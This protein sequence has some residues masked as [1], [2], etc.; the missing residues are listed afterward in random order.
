[1][2]K[3]YLSIIIPCLNEE[4]FLPKLLDDLNK[5]SP[6]NFEVIIIDGNSEDKT[7]QVA[8]KFKAKYPLHVFSTKTRNVS[9]QRNLG[10]EK[11]HGEVL[12]FFDADTRIPKQYLY[13][14][15]HAFQKK[16][17]HFLTTYIKVTSTKP[18]EKLFAVLSNSIFE[19][20]KVFQ[21]PF[22]YGAMQAVK[23]GAFFDIGG[24]DIKTKFSED[25]Q[26]FLKLNEYKYKYLLLKKPCYD[27][28]LRRLEKEGIVKQLTDY[29]QINLNILFK[30]YHVPLK[31]AYK[32]GG[33]TYSQQIENTRYHDIFQP[34]FSNI[35]QKVKKSNKNFQTKIDKIFSSKI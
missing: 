10:A 16:H 19:I 35:S 23:R 1:M 6:I 2:V 4:H 14:I 21:T 29:I 28:S 34:I 5:Q 20:G 27:Y 25:T 17:P 24:Y 9:Y 31:V 30:G 13:Q 12:V 15:S 33:S 26:L 7:V 22:C 32:M 11:S 3:P 18:S 8:Q